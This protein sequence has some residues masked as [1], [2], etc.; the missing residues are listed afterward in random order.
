MNVFPELNTRRLKLRKIRVEDVE[1]L[2]KYANNKKISDRVINIPHPYREPN[3]VFRISYVH[4]GFVAG[5][6]YVFAIALKESDEFIGEISLHLGEDKNSAQL[7]YWVGE[8]FWNKGIATEAAEAVLK[9]G[10]Q[11]LSLD[12]VYA[13]CHIENPASEQILLKNGV[14][15]RNVNGNVALYMLTKEEYEQQNT[16]KNQL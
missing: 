6:R 2:V 14:K 5:T 15:K 4:Q 3:A 11:R 13:T 7:G 9:F 8:P 10:F 1:A 12:S 16:G